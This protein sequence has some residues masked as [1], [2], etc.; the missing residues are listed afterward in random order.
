[1]GC[2]DS[3]PANANGVS[4]GDIETHDQEQRIELAFKAK[5]QNVFTA[6]IDTSKE[7]T[8]KNVPKTD[9]QRDLINHALDQNFIFATLGEEE[10][11][12]LVNAMEKVEIGANENIITQGEEGDFFYVIER[13]VFS[14][15]VNDTTVGSLGDGKSFGELALL[16][17]TPRQATVKSTGPAHLFSLD[18]DTFRYTLAR[19]SSERSNQI[20]QALSKVSLLAGLTP[21]QLSKI[22]EAVEIIKFDTGQTIIK[23][24]SEGNIF[25]MIK[26][27]TVKVSDVGSGGFNDHTLTAGS[28]FGE[29]ALITGEPRAANV[30]AETPVLLMALDRESFNS[31]LGPL[32]EVLDHNLNM[33]VLENITLFSNLTEREKSKV[34]RSFQFETFSAGTTIVREGDRGR[35]FY[36][37]KDGSA[38]VIIGEEEVGTLESGQYFGEMALL[39]DEVRKASVVA[40]TACECFALDRPT[41]NRILGSLQDIMA[42]ETEQRLSTLNEKS[43]GGPVCNIEFK[44]LHPLA[45]LGAG[46]F[47]R[48]SLV[49]HKTTKEVYALKAMIKAEIVMHK[50]Q[51]NVVQEKNVMLQANHPFILRL[52]TTFKDSSR[53]YMLL[54]FVQGGELFSVIHTARHDGVPSSQAKFYGAGVLLGLSYLHSKDIAYRDMKPENCLVDKDGYPKIVDFGFAKVIRNCKTYTL[55]GT[56]EYL[57]PEIVLGRGHDKAVDYWAFGILL[58]E[59]IAGYSPFSDP[60]GMDQVVICRNIVNGRLIFPKNFDTECK[61][62]VK[63]LLSRDPITRLGNLRG[64][65]DEIKQHQWFAS[66]DFDAMMNKSMKAPWIPKVSSVTDTS[67]FDPMEEEEIPNYGN[68]Y[69]DGSGW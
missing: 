6:G 10:R 19:S 42:R 8:L 64:G 52:H 4:E 17:N 25:Y 35:K 9:A 65:P 16:Y 56:P 29:R 24:G 11:N 69:I 15:I 41:F 39:D 14:V 54:E 43:G 33:R 20:Q 18:R 21:Y 60:Q 55:C 1:M 7:P 67:N 22:S 13:G 47:G 5:R 45:V 58:Y 36:I 28:Y 26:E 46:T 34:S 3:K 57:A 48:V 61:D 63:K 23:K 40:T 2:I 44:D 38:K 66:F 12:I 68:K 37:I 50:Q 53:L 27:G 31:L 49:Q 62:V 30:T 32:R 59:M 51:S